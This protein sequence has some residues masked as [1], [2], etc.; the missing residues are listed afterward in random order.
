[1]HHGRVW[2]QG[3]ASKLDAPATPELQAFVR[4]GL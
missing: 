3:P 1:M 2:E 4:G